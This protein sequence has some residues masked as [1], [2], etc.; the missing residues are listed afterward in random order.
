MTLERTDLAFLAVSLAG[1]KFSGLILRSLCC[2]GELE[3]GL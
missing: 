2:K 3:K 1:Q